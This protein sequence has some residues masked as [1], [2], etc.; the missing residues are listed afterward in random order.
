MFDYKKIE[1]EVI[2]CAGEYV[3]DYDI[4][5]IMDELHGIVI[6]DGDYEGSVRSVDDV[7]IW[8]ILQRYD[9]TTPTRL[10]AHFYVGD[11]SDSITFEA[12]EPWNDDKCREE[13]MS[14]IRGERGAYIADRAE[15]DDIY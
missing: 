6:T 5:G 13:A 14:A 1:A 3:D 4:A 15:I 2:E 10:T 8:E 12:S 7:D 11:D 9:T